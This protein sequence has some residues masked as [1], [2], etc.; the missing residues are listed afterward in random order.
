MKNSKKG[1]NLEE[2]FSVSLSFVDRKAI[3]DVVVE[4]G[5][6]FDAFN[7]LFDN[8]KRFVRYSKYD[9]DFYYSSVHNSREVTIKSIQDLKDKLGVNT[10]EYVLNKTRSSVD[11]DGKICNYIKGTPVELFECRL[12]SPT[13]RFLFRI[14]GS[15]EL[16]TDYCVEEKNSLLSD[17]VKFG[18]ELIHFKNPI[19]SYLYAGGRNLSKGPI[20]VYNQE[21]KITY[22]YP[23]D[24]LNENFKLKQ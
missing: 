3:I 24:Y 7:G 18:D 4:A 22:T 2:T 21:T 12:V 6:C 11:Q 8:K 5:Y 1:K 20:L 9:N 10:K 23:F 15:N 17:I 14:T 13:N 19:V 16:V